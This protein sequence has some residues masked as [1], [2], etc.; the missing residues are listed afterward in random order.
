MRDYLLTLIVFGLVPMALWR[1]WIGVLAWY[2]IGLMN[3][4]RLTWDF[5][6]TMQFAA[7]IAVPTLLGLLLTRDR[8]PVPSTSEIWLMLILLACFA[9]TT[10][11]A[12]APSHAWPQLEKVAKIVLMTLVTTMLIFGRQRIRLLFLVVALSIGF[13]GVKG[14]I[15][16]L[17]TGG[18]EMV[19]GPE[20]SFMEGNTFIG[21]A[22]N[23]VIPVLV[24]LA[25]EEKNRWVR[26]GLYL[27]AALSVV[28][29][30]FTYSRG[31][32]LGLAAIAPFVLMQLP[33]KRIKVILVALALCGAAA[34]PMIL[35]E[36]V[37]TKA[38]TLVNY[39]S[40]CSANQR[41]MSWVVHWNIATTYPFT[42]AGFNFEES[43]NGRYLEFGTDKYAHCFHAESS[44]A[45]N[46]YFQVL[47]QHG[48]ITFAFW[49]L[50]LV[51]V[52]VKLTRLRRLAR[53]SEQTAWMATYA[54]G[55]Q[56]GLVGYLV[57]GAFLSSAYFDLPWLYYALSVIMMRELRESAAEAP[58][59]HS[60]LAPVIGPSLSRGA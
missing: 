8:K 19:Q 57:S 31:A 6:Y 20:G 34:A 23:M 17:R 49:L 5:A 29:S 9:F 16:T 2:W 12:W 55:L 14:G 54:S 36:R 7:M 53:K 25:L 22:L 40:D 33:G 27:M 50:L 37:F 59:G 42:G 52:Q 28:A 11:F 13:Y 56:I 10:P 51:V 41:L 60:P 48:F 30:I 47:G 18:G 1:P 21:L 4:H 24:A 43:T 32:W 26:R 15:F 3:P 38:D 44:A 45:H 46:I 39:E 58:A 35:P